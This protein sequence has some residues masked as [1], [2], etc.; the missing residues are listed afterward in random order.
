METSCILFIAGYI[1]AFAG[2][3]LLMLFFHLRVPEGT[4]VIEENPDDA[5]LFRFDMPLEL[6]E[7]K[8]KKRIVFKVQVT[9]LPPRNN[10]NSYNEE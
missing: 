2:G 3:F 1:L 4:I 10:S 6:D 5:D 8:S 7:I 9:K